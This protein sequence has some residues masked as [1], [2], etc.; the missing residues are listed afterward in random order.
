MSWWTRWTAACHRRRSGRRRMTALQ[1]RELVVHVFAARAGGMPLPGTGTCST[2]G[3]AAASGSRSTR[4]SPRTPATLLV[5]WHLLPLPAASSPRV[6]ARR[7][8]CT[9][10]CCA[11]CTMCWC[12]RW[13]G[14][15]GDGDPRG[16]PELERE[17]KAVARP[18][19]AGVIGVALI[20]QARLA[21]PAAGLD[22][23]TLRPA[24][25]AAT[26]VDGAWSADGVLREA[27]PLGPFAVWEADPPDDRAD[28]PGDS[29][30]RDTRAQRRIVVLAA[31]DRD[32]QLSAWTWTRGMPELTPFA[33]YL[34]HAAKVRYELR[35]WAVGAGRE[36]RDPVDAAIAPLLT[37]TE[38]VAKSRREPDVRELTEAS[39]K[40]V[41]LQ[42]GEL[43]LVDTAS[44]LREM[45]RAV[46][47]AVRNMAAHAG[48]EKP[49]GL[50][51]DDADLAGWATRQL[52]NDATY[53]EAALERA[54]NVAT[55]ADQL[56]SRGLEDRR[57]RLNLALTGVIGGILMV[58]A[59]MQS[60]KLEFALPKPLLG[61]VV[62]GLG[63]L[64]LLVPLLLL[65][66]AVPDRRWSAAL[67]CLVGRSAG[68]DAPMDR[69]DHRRA[70][71]PHG[72]VGGRRGGLERGRGPGGGRA[73]R[74]ALPVAAGRVSADLAWSSAAALSGAAHPG[75][76]L[77][78]EVAVDAAR[79][80]ATTSGRTTPEILTRR[81]RPGSCSWSRCPARWPGRRRAA[82]PGGRL[83]P[84]RRRPD[85]DAA[86][87]DPAVWVDVAVDLPMAS[88]DAVVLL[89]LALAAPCARGPGGWSAAT[90]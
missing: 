89:R 51:A 36:L 88:G 76:T 34:L 90:A 24:V 84:A 30:D 13:F 14:R 1:G 70:R 27:A 69:A 41:R 49:T 6:M 8:V 74:A 4:H 20:L 59:A 29:V 32:D 46:E 67:V 81:T 50:F 83:A 43:G 52:D 31:A 62:A 53:L 28:P 56:V 10:S 60:L 80:T 58:L 35:V 40:L 87:T 15:P 22:P 63:A 17:W 71:H 66:L 54:R 23:A 72:H 79:A 37:L 77:L 47:I 45:H 3:T 68:R 2:C 21:D 25:R 12:C 19:T 55:L 9:R 85:G 57:E 33:H 38:K 48:P 11:D 7:P 16:W 65:R 61:G 82:H 78:A 75:R 44:R 73:Y 39:T 64:A 26:G 18:P 42:A 5:T 86:L